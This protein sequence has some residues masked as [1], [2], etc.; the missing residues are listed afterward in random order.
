M[1]AANVLV[2]LAVCLVTSGCRGNK[3]DKVGVSA[4]AGGEGL[5][6]APP[7]KPK[8]QIVDKDT[9]VLSYPKWHPKNLGANIS[10]AV[11]FA[12][13]DA[14]E[15]QSAIVQGAD[16]S[17]WTVTF[18]ERPEVGVPVRLRSTYGFLLTEAS[19]ARVAESMLLAATGILDAVVAAVA[20]K[21]ANQTTLD[22]ALQKQS[23]KIAAALV[24]LKSY[25]TKDG[26]TAAQVLL[27]W[28]GFHPVA[29]DHPEGNWTVD[30][31]DFGALRELG[32]FYL[33]EQKTS[34]ASARLDQGA[35]ASIDA[36][37]KP[38]PA[39]AS[40]YDAALKDEQNLA[41]AL[42]VVDTCGQAAAQADVDHADAF[43]SVVTGVDAFAKESFTLTAELNQDFDGAIEPYPVG[44]TLGAALALAYGFNS[45][46][47]AKL[48]EYDQKQ[49]KE[50]L[51]AE[52][53]K[54]V[55]ELDE[56]K[57]SDAL[58]ELEARRRY[59]DAA[60]GI[61]YVGRLDDVVI[62]TLLS[63]CPLGCMK[64]DKGVSEY[65]GWR[66]TFSFDLGAKAVT[67]DRSVDPRHEDALAFLIGGSWNPIDV[68]RL[69]AG[70]Y[71]FE[72][73]L[74]KDWNHTYY[75]GV[76]L[77]ML[78]AADLLGILGVASVPKAKITIPTTNDEAK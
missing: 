35:R 54:F 41:L 58:L 47:L 65:W 1:R 62:P 2:A 20:E 50:K 10:L 64:V 12:V 72:N 7:P 21:N 49:R 23:E 46:K 60:T 36:G 22:L 70:L 53:A 32:A 77:N 11:Q 17:A 42:A 76:T 37:A 74:S 18:P 66:H 5:A 14:K 59:Y 34:L 39:C 24:P 71:A 63:V 51:T 33:V 52:L 48:A 3:S 69:S 30:E 75:A 8:T 56:V 55:I 73:S 78:H 67:L 43:R 6:T 27:T 9:L 57:S 40:A 44:T 25:M 19:R 13:D 38:A 28:L 15:L 31:S 29:D 45:V 61:V 16:A 26:K 4:S 68:V